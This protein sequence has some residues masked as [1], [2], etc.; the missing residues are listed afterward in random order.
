M[1]VTFGDVE[2]LKFRSSVSGS[3]DFFFNSH[4]NKSDQGFLSCL[5]L[6]A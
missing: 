3:N 5:S 2:A 4:A 6:R 1:F